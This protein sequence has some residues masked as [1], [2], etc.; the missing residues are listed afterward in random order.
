M[1]DE[2]AR[3]LQFT[4][5]IGSLNQEN[6]LEQKCL[7]NALVELLVSKGVIHLDE[8]E[9]RKKEVEAALQQ[10]NAEIPTVRLIETQDK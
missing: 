7:I 2:F 6:I 10:D 3:G 1:D 8:L 5:L 9:Q 4:N